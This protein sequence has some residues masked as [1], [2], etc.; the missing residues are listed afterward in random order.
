MIKVKKSVQ[1]LA[2]YDPHLFAGR[3]KLDANENSYDVPPAIRKKI[4][5]RIAGLH[6]NRYPDPGAPILRKILAKKHKVAP[7]SIVVGNGSD[8]LIH[9][10]IQA[11]CEKGD[12]VVVPTPSFE[13]YKVLALANNAQPVAVPLNDRF[14]LDEKEIM[15]A[16][17]GA[18]MIFIAYPNNP[19]GN[20]FSGD[21]V[22]RIIRDAKCL[23]VLD[24]AYFEFSNKSFLGMLKK[25]KNLVILRTFSKA[26]S[27]AGLRLGYM[28]ADKLIAAAVNK[29]RLPYN[30][31]AVSQAC[32]EVVLKNSPNP[33]IR[34]IIAQ[35]DAMYGILKKQYPVVR[36][37]ANFLLIKVKDGMR[38]KKIFEKA[39]ISIRM[40]KDGILRNFM[41]IT[42]GKPEENRRVLEILKRG[43]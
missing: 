7:E 37:D 41:R 27:M 11:F 23:V 15:N 10:L 28:M 21:S 13:M 24:E 34:K 32:A 31:N 16:A 38:T 12:R 5:A 9:Y 29:V 1:A 39:G 3:Y 18:K 42:T 4:L 14:D 8:E 30:I 17:A 43:V 33:V 40:F 6:F 22:L 25:R 26:F 19:T 20:C 2:A 35:R 36:S